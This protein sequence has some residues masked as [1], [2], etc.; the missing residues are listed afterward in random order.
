MVNRGGLVAYGGM[1]GGFLASGTAAASADPAPA[2][3]GRR[4]AVGR[5]RHRRSRASAACCSAATSARARRCPGR[6]ASRS[7]QPGLAPP[8]RSS[9]Q[10][11]ADGGSWSF[12][13]HP[14]QIYESLVGPVPVRAP[15]ADPQVPDVLGPGVPGLGPRLRHPAPAD[16]DRPRRRSARERRSAVSTSQFIGLVSV[17]A[18]ARPAR[19]AACASTGAIRTASASGSMCPCR[20]QAKVEHAAAASAASAADADRGS[21]PRSR[22]LAVFVCAARANAQVTPA[23]A[24]DARRQR[25]R[26]RGAKGEAELAASRQGGPGPRG[27]GHRAPP[28]HRGDGPSRASVD[29]L[30]RRL[31]EMDARLRRERP[32][33]R[34][35]GGQRR[36]PRGLAVQ[37]PRR[38]L[39]DALADTA[40]LLMPHLRLQTVYTGA[41]RVAGDDGH[42]PRP[43][44]SGFSLAARRGD[45]G[46]SRR[47][48][49]FQYRLQLDAA[50]V[51]D[52]QGR[53][54]PARHPVRMLRPAR[55]ASSRS[56][57]G[58]SAGPG[59]ASWSSSTS[60]RRWQ[61]SRWSAT[62]A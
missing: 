62:S 13:V 16:R 59:A 38:R 57:T 9:T 49:F 23:P 12:P 58:C 26:R 2:V 33:R 22:R 55:S 11:R 5:A 51:A 41:D 61:R 37:V 6:S 4:G 8:R 50:A 48:P 15:D 35:P 39:R 30:R 60:R 54:R 46:G 19:L 21:A 32:A 52:D 42:R 25:R 17:V 29:D 36:G 40:F 28:H 56:R 43:I 24:D 1:I 31:D 45:P 44:V 18:R 3:G 10:L 47:Q 53:L 7:G 27:A 34:R 20:R 14:T